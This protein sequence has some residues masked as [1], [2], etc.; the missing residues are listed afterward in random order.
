MGQ[1]SD[2]FCWDLYFESHKVD[3][4]VSPGYILIRRLTKERSA[5][6]SSLRS[7]AELISLW[8]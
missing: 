4:K 1:E 8:L 2:M 5:S 3:I 7:L 6:K